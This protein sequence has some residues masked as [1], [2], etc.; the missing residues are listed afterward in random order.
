[1]GEVSANGDAGGLTEAKAH[2]M[3]INNIT[4]ALGDLALKCPTC[5]IQHSADQCVARAVQI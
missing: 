2:L 3:R 4:C 5:Q 1:M